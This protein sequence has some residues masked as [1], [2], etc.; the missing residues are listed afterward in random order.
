[1]QGLVNP[2]QI[3]QPFYTENEN[4][5]NSFNSLLLLIKYVLRTRSTGTFFKD[6]YCLYV[7]LVVTCFNLSVMFVLLSV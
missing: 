1:M 2:D 7:F 5:F 6:L 3:I 4:S